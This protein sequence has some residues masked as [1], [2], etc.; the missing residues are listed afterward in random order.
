ML[1]VLLP[2]R[3]VQAI[4]LQ[5]GPTVI[6]VTCLFHILPDRSRQRFT[7]LHGRLLEASL[8]SSPAMHANRPV[9]G[10]PD[11]FLAALRDR[12]PGALDRLP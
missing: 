1:K 8:G 7:V 9:S 6:E 11:A 4:A 2:W 10:L 5:A 3:P 12:L